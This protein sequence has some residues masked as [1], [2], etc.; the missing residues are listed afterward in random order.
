MSPRADAPQARL[1]VDPVLP[2]WL[3]D[4]TLRGL[5]VGGAKET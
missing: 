1:L 2:K 5:A 3:P 4:V